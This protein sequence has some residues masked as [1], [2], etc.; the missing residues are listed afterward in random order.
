MNLERLEALKNS[1]HQ[2]TQKEKD[3]LREWMDDELNNWTP[4]EEAMWDD[5]LNSPKSIALLERMAEQALADHDAGLTE[6][7]E[8]DDEDE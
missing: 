5:T 8:W 2:L 3:A 7:F 1:I 6:P 4:E